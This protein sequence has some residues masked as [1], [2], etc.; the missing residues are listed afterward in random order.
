[1]TRI[2]GTAQQECLRALLREVR[3][4]AGLTQVE[5]AKRIGR[6]QSFVSKYESGERRLD[7]VEVRQIC[8]AVGLS[9]AAFVRRFEESLP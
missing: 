2:S 4:G 8:K 1:V 6:P 7:L 9:L 3:I 5:L